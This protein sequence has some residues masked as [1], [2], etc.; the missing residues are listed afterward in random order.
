MRIPENHAFASLNVVSFFT[1]MPKEKTVNV[2][3]SRLNQIRAETK[4][5]WE[6]L[7]EV[8]RLCLDSTDLN[9]KGKRISKKDGYQ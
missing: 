7:E 8:L 4:I 5:P 3:R 6:D 2:V 9:F 1:N